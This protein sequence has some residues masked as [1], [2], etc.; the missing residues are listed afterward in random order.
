[1]KF[2][3]ASAFLLAGM[4]ASAHAS[5]S[6]A[7]PDVGL[8]ISLPANW[9]TLS[10]KDTL[11][12]T[13][14]MWYPKDTTVNVMAGVLLYEGLS[15]DSDSVANWAYEQSYAVK[16]SI[17]FMACGGSVYSWTSYTQDGQTAMYLNSVQNSGS[18]C[19]TTRAW[20]DRF[21]AYGTYGWQV[22]LWGDSTT[23]AKN[24]STYMKDL[25]SIKVVRSWAARQAGITSARA[26]SSRLS[27]RTQGERL[28]MSGPANAT[29]VIFD[30]RGH[31]YGRVSLDGQGQGGR[32]L[33]GI[34]S[35]SYVVRMLWRTTGGALRTGSS[36]LFLAR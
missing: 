2:P 6:V 14:Y 34:P 8:T 19:D 26:A 21:F 32:S 12:S 33:E 20:H 16:L 18:F 28:I 5:T 24:Y 36:A 15:S 30:L 3:F 25:D 9:D 4:L 29:G 1:M 27:L 7:L 11:G 22:E 31:A 35:G 17:E 23:I 10:I 13:E